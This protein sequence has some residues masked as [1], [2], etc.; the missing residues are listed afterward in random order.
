MSEIWKVFSKSE[1]QDLIGSSTLDRLVH[2]I[3]AIA[4]DNEPDSIYYKETLAKVFDAF[5][6]PDAIA[7]RLFRERFLNH[8]TPAQVEATLRATGIKGDGLSFK[9]KVARLV[10]KGWTNEEFCR[11]FLQSLKLPTSLMP[12]RDNADMEHREQVID[13]A[14]DPLKPLKD[15]QFGVFLQAAKKVEIAN[16]RFVIQMPT[17]SGKTRTAME[18]VAAYLNE[19]P[20]ESVVVWLAH[21]EELC[22]QAYEG[23]K[24]VW[25][26]L[27]Q[28]A[29]RLVRCWGAE[30]KLPYD[31]QERGF[32]IGGFQ[33]MH[34]MLSGNEVPFSELK[35]RVD[36]VIVDEA[37]K[38]L[39]AT[40]KQVT[41]ALIGN[42]TRVV[43]L[44]ATPGRSAGDA[45]EN[46]A[47]AEFFFNE[48]VTIDS[49]GESIISFLRKRKV[50]AEVWY[51]PLYTDLKYELNVKDHAYLEQFF[52]LPP[53][54]LR[55][56]G[57]DDVRNVEILK[58]LQQECEHGRQVIFFACSVEHS[59]F[60]TAM[61]L[62]LG[63][64]AAHID[65]Q[66]S[67]NRRRNTIND[68]RHRKIQ[69][70]C[71]FGVLSTGFDAPKTDLVFISRPT[72]SIVLYSQMVGRGLRGPAIGG[73]ETC[74]VIDVRDNIAG[75]SNEDAVYNY[76]ADYFHRSE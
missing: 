34:S 56:I 5:A 57:S 31:F 27:G 70:V 71:N 10:K 11:A 36:V 42:A 50:L 24:E 9:D 76:F 15:Y 45:E 22:E 64:K 75:F 52:D 18:L 6:G 53:G 13:P 48:I 67:P 55:Q 74:K 14:E 73:T 68:F 23:F 46:R 51:E 40:Y 66:T 4:A 8:L 20:E 62:F 21:S 65:G 72:A 16:S 1:L 37:H 32:I 12:S 38:V 59:K 26:H 28:R 44:T 17:G 60:V 19:A 7:D 33:K 61:L 41:K 69:V 30:A 3:P 63:F 2:L 39:A 54:I 35:E 47:L 25:R 49:G 58:R 43:G 29:V